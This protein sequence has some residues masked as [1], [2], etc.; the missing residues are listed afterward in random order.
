MSLNATSAK[1]RKSSCM[2]PTRT[3]LW[4]GMQ[5]RCLMPNITAKGTGTPSTTGVVL[6]SAFGA[7]L[8]RDPVPEPSRG[9]SAGAF[10]LPPNPGSGGA[11][12]AVGPPDPA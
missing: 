6:A 5:H 3:E 7:F 10:H 2:K 8:G 1:E 11:A 4:D 12:G 9:V